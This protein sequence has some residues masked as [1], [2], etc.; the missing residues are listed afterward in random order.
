MAKSLKAITKSDEYDDE[1]YSGYKSNSKKFAD[2]HTVVVH[3]IPGRSTD[4]GFKPDI[5]K[6]T[7]P[8]ADEDTINEI[9]DSVKAHEI[10]KSLGIK[11][12]EN[13]HKL[14][15]SQLGALADAARK[16]GYKKPKNA[17]GSTGRYF[18]DHLQKVAAKSRLN[19]ETDL[20][21]GHEMS[22]EAHELVLYA[23]N[24]H[25]LHRTSEE[26]IVK[27]LRRKHAKGVYDSEKA[28][29][30]WGYHA[31]RAAQKYAK[32]HGSK[33]HPWHKMF[34]PSARKQAAAHWESQKRHVNEEVQIDELKGINQAVDRLTKENF[35]HPQT[36]ICHHIDVNDHKAAANWHQAQALHHYSE[37]GNFQNYADDTK[38][39]G[40]KDLFNEYQ[41][42]A[43]DHLSL[44]IK[45]TK[46]AKLHNEKHLS[47]VLGEGRIKN[48]R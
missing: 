38:S 7:Y 27:N 2:L 48:G 25:H 20:N 36:A 46:L 23:D 6:A 1:S 44:H 26:P 15:L 40:E 28:K 8:R 4:A 14:P 39:A 9:N 17:N 43:N 22:H 5:K 18:H 19:D 37:H 10:L 45:H 31:D 32:D 33:D 12:G 3:Q 30:L 29:K 34:P 47:K 21:E 24:D 35:D 41:G 11:R 42:A 16:H 13:V